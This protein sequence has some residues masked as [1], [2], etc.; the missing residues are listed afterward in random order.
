[1]ALRSGVVARLPQVLAPALRQ[2]GFLKRA[3]AIYRSLGEDDDIR[4]IGSMSL[5]I[6]PGAY[7]DQL[8]RLV[9]RLITL[10]DLRA[11][12]KVEDPQVGDYMRRMPPFKGGVSARYLAINR[13]KR[14]LALDP[15]QH[16]HTLALSARSPTRARLSDSMACSQC[17]RS[18][19]RPTSG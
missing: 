15:R 11:D 3:L 10:G 19:A 2:Y 9:R 1:M 6:R 18:A 17:T 7:S 16:R 13:G 14:S 12:V 5:P 4:A 8:P